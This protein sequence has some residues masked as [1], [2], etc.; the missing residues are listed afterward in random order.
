M[1]DLTALEPTNTAL[2][3][4]DMQND[5]CHVQGFYGRAGEQ[6]REIGLEPKLVEAGIGTMKELLH[7]AR[8]AGLF[9]V[10]TRIVRDP[11]IFGTVHTLH[12]FLPKTYHAVRDVTGG[13]PLVTGSWGADTHEELKPLPGEYVVFKGSFSA[14]YQ[15]DLETMLRRR[16]VRTLIIAGTVT[17]ACVLHTAFD[18]F[19][20][21]Y[22][23]LVPSDGTASWAAELQ[24]PTLRIVDLLLGATAPTAE[25]ISA[26]S[27]P[28]ARG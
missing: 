15:T 16:G 2:I 11:A 24:G 10:H 25:L 17:Y 1:S 9:I 22:D 4:V 12:R 28:H 3:M 18:A 14:F 7:A 26:L 5:F 8:A 19:V 20:R 23:V 27:V 6:L 21:D 13:P